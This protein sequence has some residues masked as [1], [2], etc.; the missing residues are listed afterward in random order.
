MDSRRIWSQSAARRSLMG[1]ERTHNP[2]PAATSLIRRAIGRTRT[3][4]AVSFLGKRRRRFH[5][6]NPAPAAIAALAG[7]DI[8]VLGSLFKKPSD[9]IAA[10]LA[11]GIVAAANSGNLTA[12]R[13][14]MERAVWPMNAKEAMVWKLA[15]KQLSAKIRNAVMKYADRIPQASQRNPKEFAASLVPGVDLNEIE[16]EA[17]A[18]VAQT[19]AERAAAAAASRAER[20]QLLSTAGDVAAAGLTAF[21]RGGRRPRSRRRSRRRSGRRISL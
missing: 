12:A 4:R 11:P 9:K 1:V 3:K 10:G 18:A 6:G 15:E 5:R 13:G 2:S 7:L 20:A 17:R 8:P 16:A 14:L 21:A 19:K